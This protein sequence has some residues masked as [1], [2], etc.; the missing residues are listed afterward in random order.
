MN[1]YAQFGED[2]AILPVF[3]ARFKGF[4]VDVGSSNGVKDNNTVLFER[5]GWRG[6]CVEPHDKDWPLLPRNRPNSVCLKVAVWNSDAESCNFYATAPGGW[7]RV[8]GRGN[9]PEA[10]ED[11]FGIIEIQH[12]PMRTL[13]RILR[14]N[15]APAP[16]DLLSIDVEDSEWHVLNAFDLEKY[17]PRIVIIEDIPRKG[18]F[19]DYFEGYTP[20]YSWQFK[21]GL[22][23]RCV[24]GSNVIYCLN[25]EDAETVKKNWRKKH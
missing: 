7:S 12:P 4:F 3:G 16:F 8:G 15:D 20:V 11:R 24:G 2:R 14:E 5:L 22:L 23:R 1:F 17:R 13:N 6:I 18:Q 25:P 9:H 19:D 10:L 21:D